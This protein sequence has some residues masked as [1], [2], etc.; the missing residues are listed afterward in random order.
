MQP[1][2]A[3]GIPLDLGVQYTERIAI[4]V[5]SHVRRTGQPPKRFLIVRWRQGVCSPHS[6]HL[7]AMLDES[8]EFV[9]R[10]QIRGVVAADVPALG[11]SRQ[12]IGRAQYA[13]RLVCSAVYQLQELDGKFDVAQTAA[14][15][16]DLPL[17]KL[18][19]HHLLD[20]S[21]HRTDLGHEVLALTGQPHHR[22]DGIDV[23]VAEGD[24]AGHR[25]SLEQGLE[26]PG[27][28]PALVVGHVRVERANQ[29]AALTFGAKRSVDLEERRGPDAHH[30]AGDPTRL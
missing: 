13:Q 24:I 9:G 28:G 22:V 10:G 1:T 29:L 4:A 17:S 30:L 7:Q 11:Q 21:P 14:S 19:R 5:G 23:V 16:F 25:P 27:L 20:S 2:D 18:G 12:G 15:E 8:Q 3:L 6:L 26:L